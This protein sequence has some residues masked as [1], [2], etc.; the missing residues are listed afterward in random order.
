MKKYIKKDYCNYYFDILQ[1]NVGI[2]GIQIEF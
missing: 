2:H 1:K